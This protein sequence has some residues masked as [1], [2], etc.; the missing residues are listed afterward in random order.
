MSHTY[1][2]MMKRGTVI[3]YL[4]ETKN[5]Y[6]SC[7]TS[8]DIFSP[9]ISNFCYTKKYRHKLHFNRYFLI[10]LTF[11]NMVVLI[12][13]VAILMIS[14]KVATPGLLKL[15]VFWNKCYVAIISVHDVSNNFITWLKLYFRF[16]HVTKSLVTLGFLWEKLS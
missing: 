16:G 7:D 13:I 10:L 3:I 5:I 4:K 12:T 11:F 14:A 8:L 9:E 1:P 6:K 2:K 15:K